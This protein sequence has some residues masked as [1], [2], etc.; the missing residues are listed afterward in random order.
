M[1]KLS[2]RLSCGDLASPDLA[3]WVDEQFNAD[4]VVEAGDQKWRNTLDL[5]EWGSG[6][7]KNL[8]RSLES[9]LFYIRKSTATY[10]YQNHVGR[11]CVNH[12]WPVFYEKFPLGQI[13][14][15]KIP[16]EWWR[17]IWA[18]QKEI[19]EQVGVSGGVQRGVTPHEMSGLTT[20]NFPFYAMDVLAYGIYP[21]ILCQYVHTSSGLVVVYIPDRALKHSQMTEKSTLY[22]EVMWDFHHVLDDQWTFDGSRGP[23]TAASAT[24]LNP[25]RQLGY[26]DW[27]LTN[28]GQRMSDLAAMADPLLRE[29]VGMTIDRAMCDAV[30]AVTT[31]LPYVSK[32][33]FFACLDKLANFAVL[34]RM[35]SDEVEAWKWLVDTSFLGEVRGTLELIPGVA[36]EYLR[37]IVEHAIEELR[38]G[39][40]SSTDLRDL[41]NTHHGYGLRPEVVARLMA[42]SGEFNNDITLVVTPLILHFMSRP[43]KSQ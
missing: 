18:G 22:T 1:L 8:P 17:T 3:A 16:D 20:D 7:R 21:L 32:V 33:F 38:V 40:L 35:C 11:A 27:F 30:L 23:K 2:R 19:T 5:L 25:A 36:G 15:P 39:G 12:V 31:E 4:L 42:R 43:W 13:W 34:T 6:F 41:R 9:A 14:L 26:F 10:G 24:Q 29:Q 28:L 37:W